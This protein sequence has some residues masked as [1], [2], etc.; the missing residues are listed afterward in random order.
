MNTLL[1]TA[2]ILNVL[3][4]VFHIG[5]PRMLHWN[6]ELSKLTSL[7]RG[8]VWIFHILLITF[9][10]F[11]AYFS[12]FFQAE[13]LGTRLGFHFLWFLGIFWIIRLV[14]QFIYLN[15]KPGIPLALTLIFLMLS[16]CYLGSVMVSEW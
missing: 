14:L 10:L 5:F 8:V 4:A 12:F 2:G 15:A 11:S 7:N 1:T 3:L 16:L 13:L 6:T 9:L